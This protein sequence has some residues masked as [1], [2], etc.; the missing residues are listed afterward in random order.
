MKE[1]IEEEK[2][3]YGSSLNETSTDQLGNGAALGRRQQDYRM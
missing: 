2:N 3:G 1:N